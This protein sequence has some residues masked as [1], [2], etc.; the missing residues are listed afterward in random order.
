M[1]ALW[2]QVAGEFLQLSRIIALLRWKHVFPNREGSS[3]LTCLTFY[4]NYQFYF[5]LKIITASVRLLQVPVMLIKG[6][7]WV[8]NITYIHT[9][10]VSLCYVLVCV[11]Q[12]C[13]TED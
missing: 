11:E 13:F 2:E 9:C 12:K 3:T 5:L 1:I 7:Q 6:L 4:I 10:S 8:L